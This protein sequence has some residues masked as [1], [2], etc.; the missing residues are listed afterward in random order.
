MAV[1][2]KFFPWLRRALEGGKLFC[3]DFLRLHAR[4]GA[5][6]SE[7]DGFFVSSSTPVM[8]SVVYLKMNFNF[9]PMFG[10]STGSDLMLD[11][12]DKTSRCSIVRWIRYARASS[13]RFVGDRNLALAS[14]AHTQFH[15][16]VISPMGITEL[17]GGSK[18]WRSIA[19][20]INLQS[21]CFPPRY[22]PFIFHITIQTQN[23][24]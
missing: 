8:A 4:E 16:F 21:Q 5:S 7:N 18:R 11:L 1:L 2:R 23:E 19:G 24:L 10:E 9:R 13:A 20:C 17:Q 15:R 22:S 3:E 12:K 6:A 14:A